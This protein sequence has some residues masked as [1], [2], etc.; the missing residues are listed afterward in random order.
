MKEDLIF[1]DSKLIGNNF[2]DQAKTEPRNKSKKKDLKINEILG[3]NWYKRSRQETSNR[4]RDYG[5]QHEADNVLENTN[6]EESSEDK[7]LEMIEAATIFIQ[8]SFH[9]SQA[10]TK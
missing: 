5:Y 6:D 10:Y 7:N 4:E 1:K 9:E 3:I 8:K 2:Q